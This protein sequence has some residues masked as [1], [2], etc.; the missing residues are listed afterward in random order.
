MIKNAKVAKVD[1][2]LGYAVGP[3]A[4]VRKIERELG[5]VVDLVV[6]NLQPLDHESRARVLRAASIVLRVE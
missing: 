2:R 3:L 1:E 4:P 5:P 6:K